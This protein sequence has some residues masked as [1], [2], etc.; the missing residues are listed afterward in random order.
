MRRTVTNIWS[1]FP[2]RMPSRS[3]STTTGASWLLAVAESAFSRCDRENFAPSCQLP[4]LTCDRC[5]SRPTHLALIACGNEQS[6]A[7]IDLRSGV[8]TNPFGTPGTNWCIAA[9]GDGRYIATSDSTGVVRIWNGST[10]RRK[11][12]VQLDERQ[13]VA[14]SMACSP[15]GKQIVVAATGWLHEWFGQSLEWS[16]GRRIQIKINHGEREFGD[17][18]VWDI[19]RPLPFRL[20]Q[21]TPWRSTRH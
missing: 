4:D 17:V 6:T 2:R 10:N 19:S 18:A 16:D 3:P 5:C 11:Q 12:V 7:W 9:S 14:L 15:D 20:F 13:Y 21:L 1:I 8:S